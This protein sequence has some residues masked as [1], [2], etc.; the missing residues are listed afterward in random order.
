[1]SRPI[2]IAR[3]VE[4]ASN[5]L[6]AERLCEVAALLNGGVSCNIDEVKYDGQEHGILRLLFDNKQQWTVRLPINPTGKFY[7]DEFEL[8]LKIMRMTSSLQQCLHKHGMMVPRVHWSC[9]R[10]SDNP[11]GY[12]VVIMDWIDGQIL[13]WEV[14]RHR[15]EVKMKVLAQLAD[16]IFDL[17]TLTESPEALKDLKGLQLN[18]MSPVAILILQFSHI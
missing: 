5:L 7:H 11:V 14:I 17:S 6:D 15:P 3:T 1:M 12:P 16:Y 8:P 2:Q 10:W 4:E 9:L 18:G 13:D